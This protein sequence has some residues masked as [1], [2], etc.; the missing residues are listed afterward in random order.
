M[1]EGDH[2]H[3][4]IAQDGH[5][6]RIT[7]ERPAALNALTGEMCA[8]IDAALIAWADAPDL[9]AVVIDATG[10]RAF[11]AGGDVAAVYRAAVAGDVTGARGFFQTEYRMNARLFHFPKP[12]VALMQG[13]VMGG[14][15][16]LGGHGSHRIFAPDSVIAMPETAIGMVPDVGAS[17]ILARAP[18]WIGEYLAITGAHMTPADAIFAGF[19]DYVIAPEEW[20]D[21]IA[22]LA[23]TGDVT[24]ID[25]R[26]EAPPPS[27]LAANQAQIDRI[28]D[29]QTMRDILNILA[30][31]SGPLPDQMR[32]Q[33]ARNSPLAMACALELV[34]RARIRDRIED[35]LEQEY[36]YAYR[37]VEGGDFL[38]GVRAQLIDKDKAPKWRHAR[39]EDLAMTE[40]TGQ[41][42]PLGAAKLNL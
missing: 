17:L 30:L 38:E 15:V 34:H 21:L 24:E 2:P 13:Y 6:G 37:A 32:A 1:S 26:A 10:P 12:V 9:M 5:I 25:R 14:G 3:L 40:I 19:G 7:L 18:G 42:M 28:C 8:A 31:E 41:L 39:P 29:G 20:P 35:A 23:A 27:A 4:R 33:I 16:G 36:R 11:C 22:H